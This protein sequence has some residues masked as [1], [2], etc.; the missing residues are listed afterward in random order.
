MR[1]VRLL[2]AVVAAS[3]ASIAFAEADDAEQGQI[4][5]LTPQQKQ[6]ALESGG[7]RVRSQPL[8]SL[9]GDGPS[10]QIHG[11]IGAMVGTGGARGVYGTAAV[12][13]GDNA[14]AILSFEKS[15]Y[16]RGSGWIPACHDPRCRMGM[17]VIDPFR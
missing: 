5:S 7:G 11:E 1:G 3:S 14:G 6:E 2:M 16:G 15:R 10:R 9:P 17:G 13:L 12:P 4:I 8:S